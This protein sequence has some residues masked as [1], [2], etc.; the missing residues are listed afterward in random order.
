MRFFLTL[1]FCILISS[2]NAQ[3]G[4]ANNE[5]EFEEQ[6]QERITK[7]R[8]YGT[9]IPKNLDDALNQL[10]KLISPDAKVKIK[11]LPEDSV[12]MYLHAKL[13]RWMILNWGFYQGSRLSHY[14]RS[15]GVSYP[16][17]MADLLILAFHKRLNDQPVVTR[18]LIILIKERRR[19]MLEKE[20]SK[21]E[22]IHQEVHK[23]EKG[24]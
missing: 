11:A 16:D 2:L 17:D 8:L 13:G 22:I 3:D 24:Q 10:D 19:E 18:D 23:R 20:L 1:S 21:K 12:C 9:Y 14:L 6:Y 7:D 5:R 4:P 15:A